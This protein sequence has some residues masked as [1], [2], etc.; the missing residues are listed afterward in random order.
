MGSRKCTRTGTGVPVC[1][2]VFSQ[3]AASKT[4]C[5]L[6][7]AKGCLACDAG[8]LGSACS[9]WKYLAIIRFDSLSIR[10]T[11]VTMLSC[12]FCMD[13]RRGRVCVEESESKR[14][15]CEHDAD[16]SR[17]SR[18]EDG[19]DHVCVYAFWR[20]RVVESHCQALCAVS[21]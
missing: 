6:R 1:F 3:M 5:S 11:A 20:S 4:R 13:P 21:D 15:T 8:F 18:A 14:C 7:V 2:R 16:G 19:T 9:G 10:M 17:R 12:K